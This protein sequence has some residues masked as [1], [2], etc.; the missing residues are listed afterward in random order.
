M[1]KHVQVIIL[2]RSLLLKWRECTDGGKLGESAKMY[3][4]KI[5]CYGSDPREKGEYL[6]VK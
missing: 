6:G 3:G 5:E 2:Q 4:K 1:A